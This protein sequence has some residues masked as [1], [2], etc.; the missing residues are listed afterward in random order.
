MNTFGN[1]V[2]LTLFG[3]SHADAVGG[4]LD[5]LPAGTVIDEEAIA[6]VLSLRAPGTDELVSARKE[7]DTVAFLSGVRNGK[8]VGSPVSFII[9]NTD[10]RSDDYPDTLS[11]PRPSHADYPAYCKYGENYDC[12][13]GGQFSGRLTAP[14]CVAGAIAESILKQRGILAATHLYAAGDVYDRAFE[15]CGEKKETLQALN[16]EA[17]PI[18]LSEKKNT[19]RDAIR[20][21]KTKGDSLG[22]IIEGQITGL[23]PGIGQPFFYSVES[24]LAAMFFS[25]PGVKGVT[26]GEP[27][28]GALFRGSRY[29]DPLYFDTDGAVRTRTNHAGGICGGLTNGMPVTFRVTVKPTPTVAIPEQTVDLA[30]HT[31]TTLAFSGRHDPCIAVRA[32]VAVRM[33]ALFAVLDLIESR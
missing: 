12:R 7:P 17:F 26:F 31:D 3:E 23:T 4:V 20:D 2:K 8:T 11:V 18:L 27:Y 25:I 10:A 16:A 13:G 22:G 30:A 5:G 28:D 6:H 24:A 15:A 1:T 21:A 32:C 29:N 9:K 14:L 19:M 33:A